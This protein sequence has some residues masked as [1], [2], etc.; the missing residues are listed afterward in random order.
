MSVWGQFAIHVAPGLGVGLGSLL[1]WLIFRPRKR[2]V[3]PMT[4][5]E[6]AVAMA[7]ITRRAFLPNLFK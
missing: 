7:A 3:E 6:M 1:M 4:P 2:K 5:E